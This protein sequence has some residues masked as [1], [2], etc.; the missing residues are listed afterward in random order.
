MESTT[1]TTALPEHNQTGVDFGDRRHFRYT[2]P[3]LIDVH[4]HVLQTRPTDPPN[5]PP[6]GSGPDASVE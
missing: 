3:S 6:T 1:V 4:A 5:G 2:G